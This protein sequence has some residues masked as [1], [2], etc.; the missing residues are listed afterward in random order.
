MTSARHAR[1]E[2]ALLTRE[3]PPDVYGGAGV[4]VEYLARELARAGRRDGALLGRRPPGRYRR[5][6]SRRAPAVGGARR[7]RALRGGAAGVLDRP[8][9]GGRCGRG[10]ARPQSHLVREPRRPPGEA[11]P[12]HPAR[13]DGAQ[14]RADA[15]V[16]ARAARRGVRAVGLRRADGARGRRRDHRRLGRAPA[17]D[18]GVLPRRRPGAHERDLQRHRRGRVPARSWGGRARAPRDRP[19][20][21]V[22]RLRRPDHAP[23]GSHASPRCG[24]G[25]R[26]RGAARPLRGRARHARD[27]ARDRGEDGVRPQCAR[28][29]DL[30]RG[31]AAE[32]RRDSD[33]Q[34]RDRLR[35]PVR[36]RADGDR[37]SRGDGL[38][39]G[40]R[41]DRGGRHPRGGRGRRHRAARP[42]RGGARR[43]RN[44]PRPR[45]AGSGA[46]RRASTSSSATRPAP[47]RWASPAV[48]GRSSASAG[49]SRRGRR[50]RCTNDCSGGEQAR[51]HP[52][53]AA[54]T[55]PAR[56][57]GESAD[58]AARRSRARRRGRRRGRL[59]PAQPR[60]S[61]RAGAADRGRG[62]ARDA[63]DDRV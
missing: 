46:S 58:G 15:P 25:D 60:R 44:A 37:Q 56:R 34:P 55:P 40:G 51:D 43:H 10:R 31:H 52:G 16:E 3:Y 57:R 62:G 24:A 61:A 19:S 28:Q 11:R 7:P 13:R 54:L 39:G 32:A 35:L 23:E 21:S 2:V 49:T 22:S 5:A 26:S 59:R 53:A 36:L 29:R 42:L 30:D 63:A 14:P 47:R 9:D 41:C 50:W 1:P 18:P 45:R 4:H 20:P 8:H 6:G 17:R 48:R 12:L 27:R 33:P 38:R